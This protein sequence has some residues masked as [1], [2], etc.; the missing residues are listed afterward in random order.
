[1]GRDMIQTSQNWELHVCATITTTGTAAQPGAQV[2]GP[3]Q[4]IAYFNPTRYQS[5]HDNKT[6]PKPPAVSEGRRRRGRAALRALA[7]AAARRAAQAPAAR[8][9][10]PCVGTLDSRGLWDQLA[11]GQNPNR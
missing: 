5:R 6:P 4:P 10:G 9:R 7:A 2:T 8:G 11:R 1:M 3:L